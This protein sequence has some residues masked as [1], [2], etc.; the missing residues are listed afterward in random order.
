MENS[1]KNL[2]KCACINCKCAKAIKKVNQC[3]DLDT[4]TKYFLKKTL[5]KKMKKTILGGMK[6]MYD[7]GR[8]SKIKKG[9]NNF[10]T[11]LLNFAK[12]QKESSKKP[13]QTSEESTNIFTHFMELDNFLNTQIKNIEKMTAPIVSTM[14]VTQQRKDEMISAFNGL[15][16]GLQSVYNM[17]EDLLRQ[18][19]EKT[20]PLL[21]KYF[22]K[23]Y[24][25]E[26][27]WNAIVEKFKKMDELLSLVYVK[28]FNRFR[29]KY[30]N[31][32]SQT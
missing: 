3:K 2:Q 14:E 6:I 20:T 15:A 4:E 9:G 12:Q 17:I 23:S 27:V 10:L 16:D 25:E 28:F 26:D 19:K 13:S 31:Y 30:E 5:A 29:A 18:L 21:L 22:G 32:S 24:F 1:L 7:V 8:L 11:K